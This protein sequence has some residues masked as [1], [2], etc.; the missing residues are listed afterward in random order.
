MNRGNFVTY[1]FT[2]FNEDGKIQGW[3]LVM[4]NI[5]DESSQD[6]QA[7]NSFYKKFPSCLISGMIKNYHNDNE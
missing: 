7:I 4:N 2:Y 5:G 1:S 3:C 6:I